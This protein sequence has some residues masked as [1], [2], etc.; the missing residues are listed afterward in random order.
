[1]GLGL[2]WGLGTVG[3]RVVLVCPERGSE[4]WGWGLGWGWSGPKG[5]QSGV[6]MG[7]GAGGDGGQS[8]WGRGWSG[9]EGV[10]VLGRAGPGLGR[11]D[12]RVAGPKSVTGPEAQGG[13]SAGMGS[14]QDPFGE[15]GF[16]GQGWGQPGR[17]DPGTPAP[18]NWG[19]RASRGATGSCS[20]T[21]GDFPYLPVFA[22]GLEPGK[23]LAFLARWLQ[24]CG[25]SPQLLF[26]RQP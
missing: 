13:C 19:G 15:E 12:G 21:G 23:G 20:V 18:W 9:R 14:W 6:R 10:E 25:R 11:G 22:G 24:P 4:Q 26:P 1:M 3:T 2:G 7:A 5:A 17:E 8:W 16:R